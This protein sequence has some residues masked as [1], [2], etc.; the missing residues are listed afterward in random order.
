MPWNKGLSYLM[1]DRKSGSGCHF[2]G[3]SCGSGILREYAGRNR[4]GHHLWLWECSSCGESSGPSTVSHLSRSKSCRKCRMVASNNPNWRGYESI[5][6]RYLSQIAAGAARRGIEYSVTPEELWSLWLEQNCRCFYTS[7]PLAIGTDASVDRVDN[8]AGYVAG[9]VR[10]VHKDVNR[11]KSDFSEGRF[12]E[13]C[14][15]VSD[16]S[17]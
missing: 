15:L 8:A 6:G 1:A 2:V 10:W 14:R 11:M 12:M 3:E 16:C 9:N 17:N 13:I 7:L 4:H 5:P